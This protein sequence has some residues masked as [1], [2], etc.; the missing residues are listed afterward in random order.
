MLKFYKYHGTGN[1]FT[2][3]ERI[4]DLKQTLPLDA[5][6][7]PGVDVGGAVYIPEDKSGPE[8]VRPIGP[9]RALTP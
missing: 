8:I 1:D 5:G 6:F 9:G 3:T 7:R 4:K 2:M